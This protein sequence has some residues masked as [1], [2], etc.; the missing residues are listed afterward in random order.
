MYHAWLKV[1][2]H[3]AW[4]FDHGWH[5]QRVS[6]SATPLPHSSTL[7]PLPGACATWH[8][9]RTLR[10]LA[11]RTCHV[12]HARRT[13]HQDFTLRRR[14]SYF[15]GYAASIRVQRLSQ[16]PGKT[17]RAYHF[18]DVRRAADDSRSISDGVP[19]LAS[20]GVPR[21]AS[22]APCPAHV[23]HV[24]RTPHAP[25][26]AR[27]TC[28]TWHARRT[29][30][31]LPGARATRGMYAARSALC[32]AHVPH[33]A[34][35]PPVPP[36][37]GACAT[38]GIMF[39]TWHLTAG[40]ALLPG[41]CATRGITPHAPPLAQLTLTRACL[42]LAVY[43]AWSQKYRHSMRHVWSKCHMWH[44]LRVPGVADL[45]PPTR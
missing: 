10:P 12:W 2:T 37:P 42:A 20:P 36:L 41:S 23:P 6:T 31:P 33:V 22:P 14:A 24:A 19:R 35:T 45:P 26:S 44:D 3:C 32:L 30:R 11:W 38:H 13:L 34:C 40:A 25:P 1:T 39:H 8:A 28:H 4:G 43:H 17:K 9:H 21:L 7:I 16:A 29:L 15:G 18:F 5:M 27:R